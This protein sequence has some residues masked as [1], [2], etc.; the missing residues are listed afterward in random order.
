MTPQLEVSIGQYSTAG[1]KEVNQDFHGSCVPKG[2]QLSSKGIVVALADG[3]SSSNVS[4]IASESA[5][6]GFLNDYYSTPDAWSAKTS[7]QR[8][9]AATNSWLYAQTQRNERRYNSDWGYVCTFSA[10]VLKSTTAHL[11]HCG[12]TRIYRCSGTGLEQLTTDHRKTVSAQTSYLTRALGF[13]ERLEVDY[14]QYAVNTG[15]VFVLATDGVYEFLDDSEITSAIAAAF[16]QGQ[17][18]STV[19]N[20]LVHSALKRG[21]TDNLTLQI[22]RVGQLPPRHHSELRAQVET[23]ALPPPL[24]ARMEFDGFNII[25]D[26]HI[27]SRSHV[28]LAQDHASGEKVVLKTPS[29]EMKNDPAYLENFLMEEWIAKRINSPN[30]LKAAELGRQQKFLYLATEYIDGQTLEQWMVDHPTPDIVTVRDMVN[31]IAQGL[32]AFHR[33]EMVHQDLRP[34]NIMIDKLGTVKIIDF[35][36]TKVAGITEQTDRSET[37]AG[38]SQYTAPEIYLGKPSSIRSDI[39]SFGVIVYEMLSGQLP[40]GNAIA[41]TRSKKEQGR[42]AYRMLSGPDRGVPGWL[43]HA[44]QNA[45]QV[46]PLNRYEDVYEF[47]YEFKKPGEAYLNKR[48]PPLLERNPV[49]FWKTLCLLGLLVIIAQCTYQLE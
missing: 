27:S 40:Y 24:T 7:G 37:I 8:V 20:A 14:R 29:V 25:R 38:T 36:A 30:V 44:L 15:D 47:V 23:L 32:N 5:V 48:K 21:S 19:A 41:R 12:D 1:Q 18:L 42:L 49:L 4:Q 33:Q 43:D 11:F 39:F 3:I 17:E 6:A 16:E 9:L 13:H 22:V 46:D 28:F 26:L 35:G 10:L 34:K 45:T 2:A 31:Q